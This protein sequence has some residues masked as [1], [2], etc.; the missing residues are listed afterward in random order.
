MV[1]I[2]SV[3]LAFSNFVYIVSQD[4]TIMLCVIIWPILQARKLRLRKVAAV[5]QLLS[6]VCLCNPMDCSI[7]GS[8]VIHYLLE[9]AQIHAHCVVMPANHLI[10]S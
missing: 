5:V 8:S 2:A 1:L 9:F 3:C 10:L 7:P 6:R 4:L